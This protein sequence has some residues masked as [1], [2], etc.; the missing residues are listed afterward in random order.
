VA[1]R[2]LDI[3]ELPHVVNYELPNV[4]EDYVHRIGRT[5]RAGL[6]GQAV[7]LV[8]PDE[9]PLLRDIERLLKRPVQVAV[10]PAFEI[11]M[12]LGPV[13]DR[14][15]AADPRRVNTAARPNHT[16]GQ[17]RDGG[18]RSGRGRGSGAGRQQGQARQRM[19]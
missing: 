8:S 6:T 17:R 4:P 12:A 15:P 2:G 18:G 11:N 1:A 14:G 5:A 10:V 13:T 16:Q 3:K 7:S 19:H 9:A